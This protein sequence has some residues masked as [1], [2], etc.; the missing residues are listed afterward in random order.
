MV[1]GWLGCWMGD[2]WRAG[3]MRVEWM[4]LGKRSGA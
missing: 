1:S 4:A 2:A 3:C